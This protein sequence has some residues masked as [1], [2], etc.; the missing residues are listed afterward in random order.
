RWSPMEPSCTK[1]EVDVLIVGYVRG[2][3][4]TG[5]VTLVTTPE[6]RVILVDAGD[7]WNGAE[8]RERLAERGYA[9]EEMTD[10]LITHGHIDHCGN[11]AMFARARFF[12]DG[13]WTE[14]GVYGQR[15]QGRH[16]LT[17]SVWI[18]QLAGHTPSDLVLVVSDCARGGT[19][20]VAGDLFEDGDDEAKWRANSQ[21][22]E[23]HERSREYV[24]QHADWIVPGH[25]DVFRVEKTQ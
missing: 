12:M 22:C 19:T 5:T 3:R 8:L 16:P 9:P 10:V 13:D 6:G 7:P 24:R 21:D 2:E 25:G 14:G 23:T 11:V 20:V 4:A 1:N 18:E 15:Q 17:A